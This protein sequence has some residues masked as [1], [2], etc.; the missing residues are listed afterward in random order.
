MPGLRRVMGITAIFPVERLFFIAASV[1]VK[2]PLEVL[3]ARWLFRCKP[4]VANQHQ[5]DV[6]KA[7]IGPVPIGTKILGRQDT[8]RRT[9]FFAGVVGGKMRLAEKRRLVAVPCQGPGKS[10]F[11]GLGIQVDAVVMH[12]VGAAQLPGQDRSP[13]RLADNTRGNAGGKTHAV[14][15]KPVQMRRFHTTAFNTDTIAA[16]LVGGNDEEIRLAHERY[17]LMFQRCGSDFATR[18]LRAPMTITPTERRM[19]SAAIGWVKRK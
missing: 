15:A 1:A 3:A 11:P 19:K 18:A 2:K 4:V 9:G 6:L 12:A 10:L 7:H 14:P 16:L 13:C 17:F 8:L 5:F